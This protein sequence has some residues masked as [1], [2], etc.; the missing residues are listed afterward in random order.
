MTGLKNQMKPK[1]AENGR[2]GGRP[3]GSV[4]KA[5]ADIRELARQYAPDAL[6]ELARLSVNAVSEAARVG[7]IKEI[8]DRA[9]G[10]SSQALEHSGPD[11][12]P[13]ETRVI[14][15]EDR[16]Q[17]LEAFMARTKFLAKTK[18]GTELEASEL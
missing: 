13:I 16:V 4:N 7:A 2:L 17:A 8:L 10:K 12:G 18:D 14:T 1:S 5:T 15:D 9:Y 11:K 3:K 6:K